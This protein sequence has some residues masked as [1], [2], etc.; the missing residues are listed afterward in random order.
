MNYSWKY[1]SYLKLLENTSMLIIENRSNNL[2][3]N[4]FDKFFVL[5]KQ[6]ISP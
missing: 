1:Y 2:S 4:Y 3:K 6:I 5:T